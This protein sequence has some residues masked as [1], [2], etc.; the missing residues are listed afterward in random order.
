MCIYHIDL[1][2]FAWRLKTNPAGCGLLNS[3]VVN[4]G[5]EVRNVV[6]FVWELGS[7]ISHHSIQCDGKKGFT[8]IKVRI[9]EFATKRSCGNDTSF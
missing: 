7:D 3:V 5:V 9:T 1:L 8:L 4:S 6:T 2:R